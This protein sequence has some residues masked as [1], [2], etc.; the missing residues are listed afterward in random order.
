MF[1]T[2][3]AGG[4][5]GGFVNSGRSSLYY[6]G[7]TTNVTFANGTTLTVENVARVT[8]NF[9]TVKD[10]A[11]F[12]RAF[13][14]PRDASGKVI[15]IKD[16]VL[17]EIP[18]GY[19][20]AVVETPDDFGA[21]GY[22][23]AGKGLEDVAVL[24]A[25]TFDTYSSDFQATVQEFLAKAS[26]DGKKKL[27]VDLQ[28]N[29]GGQ[30]LLA[31]DFFRQLFPNVLQDGF[32][33]FKDSA[34]FHAVSKAISDKVANL[35]ISKEK[36]GDLIEAYNSW[37]NYR[38]DLNIT[39]QP[40]LTFDDKFSPQEFHN[41]NFTP[42][43]RFNL[44]NPYNTINPDYGLGIEISGYGT[45]ANL[46]QHFKAENIV[47]IS[48]G[49]CA[50]A[51]TVAAE[52]LRVQTGVKFIALGGRPIAGPM[53]AIGGTKGSQ[54]LDM[55][56]LQNFVTLAAK[57]TKDPALLAEFRRYSAYPLYRSVQ[58]TMNVRDQILRHDLKDEIAAQFVYQ[59]ADCHLF[60]STPMIANVTAIWEASAHAAFNGAKCAHGG[61]GAQAA[62]TVGPPGSAIAYLQTNQAVSKRG[63]SISR[64]R[65]WL[66]RHQQKVTDVRRK[67]RQHVIED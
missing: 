8:G 65:G 6:S 52:M 17:G 54:I 25:T 45:R 18:N 9:S 19:P 14:I 28:T 41:T 31:Y 51:C 62:K 59:P 2:T 1:S 48:D 50:S 63:E 60:W 39:N 32:S 29:Q 61:F 15:H 55:N 4:S 58:S 46:T 43:Y 13:C 47:V 21:S 34:G 38:A 36:D 23:L 24:I 44:S 37:F 22:Y 27:I 49:F 56:D 35:D 3:A 10:G 7:S 40:F 20:N 11:S 53:Q 66:A 26:A 12:Y 42:I 30:V 64:S 5:W 33:H 67:G 16:G 57:Y